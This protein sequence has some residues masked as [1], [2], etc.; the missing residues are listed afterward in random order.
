MAMLIIL[1]H[2]MKTNIDKKWDVFNSSSTDSEE[3]LEIIRFAY[4]D[5][6]PFSEQLGEGQAEVA[7]KST[8]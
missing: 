8:P 5:I 4:L 1:E 3:L 2:L 7:E 6:F